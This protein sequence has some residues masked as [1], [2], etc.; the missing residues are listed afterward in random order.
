MN[1]ADLKNPEYQRA[2][3]KLTARE[4]LVRDFLLASYSNSGE[5]EAKIRAANEMADAVLGISAEKI[6]GER[7]IFRNG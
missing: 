1:Q 3:P 4:T 5:K 7:R 2:K 6:P